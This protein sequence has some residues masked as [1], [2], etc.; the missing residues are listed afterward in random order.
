[1]TFYL[2]II[3]IEINPWKF[4]EKQSKVYK[5]IQQICRRGLYKE[6]KATKL[7]GVNPNTRWAWGSTL[8][9]NWKY[10]FFDPQDLKL[11]GADAC[12]L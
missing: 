1:M 7:S 4:G 12:K 2:D 8:M 10:I 9:V 6:D 5:D 11:C 3:I